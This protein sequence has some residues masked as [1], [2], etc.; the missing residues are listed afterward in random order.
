MS[1][2][3]GAPSVIGKQIRLNGHAFTVVGVGPPGFTGT[4]VGEAPEGFVAMA[5]QQVLLPGLGN[6]LPRTSFASR[7]IPTPAT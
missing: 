4:E 5:M 1:R 7:S 6:T 2:Y 3:A